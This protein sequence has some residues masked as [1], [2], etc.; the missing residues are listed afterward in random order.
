MRRPEAFLAAL[1]LSVSLC[2]PASAVRVENMP[3]PAGSGVKAVGGAGQAFLPV[4]AE[5]AVVWFDQTISSAAKTAL[6]ASLGG[7]ILDE[8]PA[9][10]WS[11]LALAP[12][13][14]VADALTVLRLNPAVKRAEA[15]RVYS[16]VRTPNDPGF[17]SQ[18]QFSHI[19]APG[20][21]EFE[22]G[23]SCLT[24]VAVIDAG[25][26]ATQPDLSAKLSGLT[27]Q[28]CLDAC[29]ADPATVTP[30]TPVAACQHGTEVA[31]MAAA[32]TDNGTQVAGVSWGSKILSMRVFATTDCN[33]DCSPSNSCVTTDTR[34][35]NAL[36]YLA[37]IQNTATYG[38]I[39]A[40]MSLGCLPGSPG[41]SACSVTLQPAVNAALTKGVVIVAAAGNDGPEIGRA[42]V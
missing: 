29:V 4:A 39:V 13:S 24:T 34:M 27:H 26:E 16:I 12:G 15:N 3:V 1:L 22:V 40:N 18:F 32:S 35:A 41:C 30:G 36:T 42:H 23:T 28:A 5:E 9:L 25:I 6:V 21:W 38:H 2:A 19:D 20:G 17:S 10:G 8:N 37:G 31:G 11:H 14:H 33:T 7:R